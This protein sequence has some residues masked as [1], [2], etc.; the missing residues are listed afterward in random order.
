MV[1]LLVAIGGAAGSLARYAA[2]FFFSRWIGNPVPHAT[3][4]VNVAGCA[5]A[6]VLMGLVASQRITLTLEERALI[7]SGILGGL[8]TFSGLGLDTLLLLQEGRAATAAVNVL[9]Q[10]L[11]GFGILSL[12]Y[13]MVR[14]S[15]A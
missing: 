8:T 15:F 11:A 5:A 14:G 10:L 12:C 7:F 2:A 1:W 9:G 4:I 3:A 6:G 13:R